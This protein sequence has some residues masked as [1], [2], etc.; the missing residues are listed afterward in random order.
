[1]AEAPPFRKAAVL[2]ASGSIG[3]EL[4]IELLAKGVPTRV[5]SRNIANLR[6]SFANG[7]V[8]FQEADLTDPRAMLAACE[9]CNMLFLC[10][11]LPLEHYEQHVAMGRNLAHAMTKVKA[12]AMLISGYW[13]Y[14]PI[15]ETPIREN[16]PRRGGGKFAQIRQIQEDLLVAA[17]AAVVCLPDFFGP[18]AS[19]S[20]INDGIASL[21]K[22]KAVQWPGDPTAPRDFLFVP[23]IRAILVNLATHKEAFGQRWNVAG[24]GP[25][26]PRQLLEMAADRVGE[27]P[28]VRATPYW[29]VK[30]AGKVNAKAK[31]FIDLYP[32]YARPAVMDGGALRRVIG[33]YHFTPYS[34]AIDRTLRWMTGGQVAE[35]A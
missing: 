14:T 30:L 35:V 15:R 17:G 3:R 25:I 23:D 34:Q 28:R 13:S 18:G 33:D 31:S 12:K 9:G 10:A 1:M 11:G 20:F 22:G 8:E 5:V 16:H 19:N 32:I 29:M 7:S 27:R 4:V 21:A 26:Q 24:S 2:G 6:R